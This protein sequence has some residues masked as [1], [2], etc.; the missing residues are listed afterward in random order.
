MILLIQ[1]D[2]LILKYKAETLYDTKQYLKASEVYKEILNL[3]PS[4]LIALNNYGKCLYY[5]GFYEDALKEYEKALKILPNNVLIEYNKGLALLAV[6]DNENAKKQFSIVNT[7]N[8]TLD[9]ETKKLI[10]W[11]LIEK[12]LGTIVPS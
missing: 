2:I 5:M 3:D 6:E 10:D 1:P 8:G 12:I 11:A 4:D 7:G 9:E